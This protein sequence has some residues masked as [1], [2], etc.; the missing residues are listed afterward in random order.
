MCPMPTQAP[1]KL[2][3]IIGQFQTLMP[4]L[5]HYIDHMFALLRPLRVRIASV[6]KRNNVSTAV[7]GYSIE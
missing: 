6:N 3:T 1:L 5:A 7:T 2:V 4:G